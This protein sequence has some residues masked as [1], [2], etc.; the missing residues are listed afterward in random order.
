[1]IN[2]SVVKIL[3]DGEIKNAKV[4]NGSVILEGSS[5]KTYIGSPAILPDSIED[6]IEEWDVRVV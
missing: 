3:Y 2:L 5:S 6:L 4:Q 1:M